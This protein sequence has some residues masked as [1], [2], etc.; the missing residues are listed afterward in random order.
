[1]SN[2]SAEQSNT[3]NVVI[4]ALLCA[5]AVAYVFFVFLPGQK[6]IGEMKVQL[7][8]KQNYIL[9]TNQQALLIDTLEHKIKATLE[10]T[11]KW[12]AAAPE[13]TNLASLYGEITAQAKQAGITVVQFDPEPAEKLQAVWRIDVK[14]G[15][16]GDFRP[17]YE[18]IRSV[19]KNQA[20]IWITEVSLKPHG[21]NEGEIR[22]E[23]ILRIFAD[24]RE[25]SG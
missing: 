15:F 14:V 5:G 17:C 7:S 10:F 11:E 2:Q 25:I 3:R 20:T 6:K 21:V 4:T 16:E 24:N 8:D 18:F 23:V 1:M 9:K 22:G 19:E 13:E 12:Q